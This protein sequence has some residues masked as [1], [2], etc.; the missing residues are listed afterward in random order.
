MAGEIR[1]LDIN[2]KLDRRALARRFAKDRRIQ[3]R[4]VLTPEA[5]RNVHQILS[6]ETPWGIAW[7][8]GADGPHNIPQP[9]LAQLPRAE[10]DAI[11]KKLGAA[12][13]GHDYGFL[14]AQY[15]MLN[16]Y[17]EGWAPGGP[18]EALVE[19]IN[20]TPFMS[21]IGEVTGISELKKA[22]A[23]A[24]LYAPNQFLAAHDDSHVAEGWQVAYVLNMCAQEW[25]PEW[26]GYLN[27][28]DED[29]DIVQGFRPRFNALNL[30]R[31]PQRHSVSYVPPFAPVGRFAITG[32]FR[33]L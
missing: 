17:L 28:H 22:D 14:Y 8:A 25:R 23:Q 33:D 32:W 19:L 20:D 5:A 16:A 30:F 15:P 24:T 13:R 3:I 9:K 29:G 31:V 27:F 4:D 10:M 11:Q 12:L 18:H 2:P 7:H 21:F 6:R 26:G 1:L